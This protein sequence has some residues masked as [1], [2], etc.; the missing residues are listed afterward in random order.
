MGDVVTMVVV[1]VV[2]GCM[3]RHCCPASGVGGMF[4]Q[5]PGF[6]PTLG[7][8]EVQYCEGGKLREGRRDITCLP[9]RVDVVWDDGVFSRGVRD[10]MGLPPDGGR[11]ERE[12]LV[13]S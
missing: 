11:G 1:V 2:G 9:L 13:C 6:F 7:L 12:G 4:L 5:F 8:G 3:E 10:E